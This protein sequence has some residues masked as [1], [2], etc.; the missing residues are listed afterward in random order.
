[1]AGRKPYQRQMKR[2][3][4]GKATKTHEG[5]LGG[6]EHLIV[7]ERMPEQGSAIV[8]GDYRARA[9][10]HQRWQ[11]ERGTDWELVA[12]GDPLADVGYLLNSGRP[13]RT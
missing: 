9:T 10:Y 12:A 2:W 4:P 6:R 1:M 11:G 7:A 8:H 13:R 3:Q 5:R